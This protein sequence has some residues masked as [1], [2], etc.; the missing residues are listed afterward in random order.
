MYNIYAITVYRKNKVND[1]QNL[2]K[3][4][5]ASVSAKPLVDRQ[6]ISESYNFSIYIVHISEF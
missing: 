2:K 1:I 3:M 5:N 4:L 6:V